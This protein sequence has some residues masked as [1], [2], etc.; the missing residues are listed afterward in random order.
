MFNLNKKLNKLFLCLCVFAI[1]L[2]I[3]NISVVFANNKDNK[4]PN[5]FE[6]AKNALKN[7][8]DNST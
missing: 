3:I 7:Y 8:K 1:F 4:G 6:D 5:N 2:S